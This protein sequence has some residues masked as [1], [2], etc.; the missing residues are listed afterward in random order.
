MTIEDKTIG[1]LLDLLTLYTDLLERMELPSPEE[2]AKDYDIQHLLNH[3]L[4]TAVETCIDIASHIASIQKLG[5]YQQATDVF[6]LLAQHQI[7]DQSLF[8]KMT[9]AVKAR[10]VLVHKY[11][12][13]DYHV[14]VRNLEDDI[15]DLREFGRQINQ[16]LKARKSRGGD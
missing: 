16:Y 8:Q 9:Q 15:A 11:A 13:V 6:Q 3:R 5:G 2:I 12:D 7:I 14:I 4:H 10:N 1:E